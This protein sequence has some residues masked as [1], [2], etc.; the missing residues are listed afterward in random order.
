VRLI[1]TVC[2]RESGT[3]RLPVTR[4]AHPRR[5]DARATLRALAGIVEARGL[6]DAVRLREAC[7]GGCA[8]S[9]P[10]VS[11]DILA[12]TSHDSVAVDWKTYVYSLPT[13]SCL[14]DVIDEN[15]R[16][17]STRAAP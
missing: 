4:G 9:G 17:T 13:L 8:R 14:A 11:V 6:G 15:L 2:P 1:V 3:V 7:A 10:N 5:L 12:G 16:T